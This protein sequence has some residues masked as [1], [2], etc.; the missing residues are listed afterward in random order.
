MGAALATLRALLGMLEPAGSA[1][2][3]LRAGDTSAVDGAFAGRFEPAATPRDAA[4]PA[5]ATTSIAEPAAAPAR[6]R[7]TGR[8]AASSSR[9]PERSV[10]PWRPGAPAASC[11]TRSTRMRS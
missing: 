7:W 10:A 6:S 5:A 1:A 9:A 11:S 2:V 4:S 8:D 3:G